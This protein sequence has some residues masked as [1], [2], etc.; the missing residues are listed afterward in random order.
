MNL[1]TLA[2][3]VAL[4]GS[5][6]MAGPALAGKGNGQEPAGLAKHGISLEQ[7]INSD[8]GRGNGGERKRSGEWV[9][10]IN[11]EDGGQDVDPGNSDGNN[12]ACPTPEGDRPADTSC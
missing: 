1:K 9:P 2:A 4:G 5:L 6:A 7:T 10:T 12:N 3:A 8:A 11:G